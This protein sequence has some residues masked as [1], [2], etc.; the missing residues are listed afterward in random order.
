MDQDDKERIGS[1]LEELIA[2]PSPT[3]MEGEIIAFLRERLSALGF[4]CEEEE[5]EGVTNLIA[6]K[7]TPR[8]LVATHLDTVPPWGHPHAFEPRREGGKV[9]GRGA[10]DAKG[11]IAALLWALEVEVE[12]AL[13]CFFSDEEGEG[14]GSRSF[15]PP[16]GIVEGVVLEPTGLRLGV[17]QAGSIEIEVEVKGRASHGAV[18][19]EGENALEIFFSFYERLKR[20]RFLSRSHPLFPPPRVTLGYLRGGIDPQVT[21]ER[22]EAKLDIPLLPGV[23]V[24]E[25]LKELEALFDSF[26]LQ[27]HIREVDRP[28]TEEGEVI[29]RVAEA[30]RRALAEEPQRCGFPA[31]T[32]ASSLRRKGIRCAILGAGEL[33]LAHT[34]YE[35]VSID[36]LF[37][38]G[39][40][41]R[42]LLAH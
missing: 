29:F 25:A 23:E 34:P 28:W 33:A 21:P 7:G 8:L 27:W 30:F 41:L 22:C 26:P 15:T 24:D 42:E 20:L 39:L 37:K 35:A 5:A 10:V 2:I 16:E 18:P 3:G 32:D 38:L 40:V 4:S 6:R 19:Q 9:W 11:Q 31:W 17:A 13:L 1:L 14:R 36:E 12:D